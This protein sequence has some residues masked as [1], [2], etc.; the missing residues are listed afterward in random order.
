MN[1]KLLHQQAREILFIVMD[2]IVAPELLNESAT[3]DEDYKAIMGILRRGQKIESLKTQSANE[4]DTILS[5]EELRV[6]CLKLSWLKD[7]SWDIENTVGF[8]QHRT[9]L[10]EFRLFYEDA[11][12][13]FYC[14]C[15]RGKG[16]EYHDDILYCIDCGK[17]VRDETPI[18]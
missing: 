15:S 2:K 11:R 5:D 8:E 4:S 9:D 12:E 18:L 10:L 6:R 17:V 3:G 16:C 1:D 13:A 7:P 14:T